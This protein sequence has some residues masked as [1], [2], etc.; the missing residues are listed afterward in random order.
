MYEAIQSVYTGRRYYE[1]GLPK[2]QLEKLFKK[3]EKQ[4]GYL[5][6]T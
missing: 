4:C 6:Y 1:V 3:K 2:G 5:I